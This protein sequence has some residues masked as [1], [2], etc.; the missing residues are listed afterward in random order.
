MNNQELATLISKYAKIKS[1]NFSTKLSHIEI[2]YI[3]G[4]NGEEEGWTLNND[5]PNEFND[6]RLVANHDSD[7]NLQI[8]GSWQATTEPGDRY[9]FNPMNPKGAARIQFGQS[10]HT[11]TQSRTKH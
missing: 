2:V 11:A 3:E 8:I 1:Y 4:I 6:Q 7:G 10:A 5:A 9:T